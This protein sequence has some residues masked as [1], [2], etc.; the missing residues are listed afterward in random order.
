MGKL[1]DKLEVKS[2]SWL[3][4]NMGPTWIDTY[5]DDD[6]NAL[7]RLVDLLVEFYDEGF[8]DGMDECELD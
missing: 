1:R 3:N 4:D 6:R 2:K 5:R 8:D 7:D